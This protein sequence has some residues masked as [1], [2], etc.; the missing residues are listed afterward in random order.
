MY[1]IFVKDIMVSMAQS[2]SDCCKEF[3]GNIGIW[4]L[5]HEAAS[6]GRG[7]G[8]PG[9]LHLHGA[10]REPAQAQAERSRGRGGPRGS[11]GLA[12]L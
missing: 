12:S 1:D 9:L 8:R 5:L 11:R 7:E 6:T 3:G 2:K 10:L 4:I